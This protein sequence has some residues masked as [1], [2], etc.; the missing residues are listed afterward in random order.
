MISRLP[1]TPEE[2]QILDQATASAFVSFLCFSFIVVWKL[3]I[4]MG[5]RRWSLLEV[6]IMGDM[7]LSLEEKTYIKKMHRCV[8]LD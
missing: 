8:K 1:F 7:F 5:C 6:C 4:L 2:L 3:I